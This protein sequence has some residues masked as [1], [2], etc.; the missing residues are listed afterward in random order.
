MW[1]WASGVIVM[2]YDDVSGRRGGFR[3]RA[4]WSRCGRAF[5]APARG[6][7]CRREVAQQRRR[8]GRLA[9][10]ARLVVAPFVIAAL[11]RCRQSQAMRIDVYEGRTRLQKLSN[12]HAKPAGRPAPNRPNSRR[13]ALASSQRKRHR[14]KT[15]MSSSGGGQTLA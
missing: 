13:G 4:A 15:A 14:P 2:T 1:S 9:R 8:P 5:G 10:L 3:G 7:R 11:K 12:E 6:S